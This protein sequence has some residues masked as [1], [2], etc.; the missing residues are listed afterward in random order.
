M[1]QKSVQNTAHTEN[2]FFAKKRK[3]GLSYCCSVSLCWLTTEPFAAAN[4]LAF[5]ICTSLNFG[6]WAITLF[7]LA[8][9]ICTGSFLHCR[10]THEGASA[11]ARTAAMPI[12]RNIVFVLFIT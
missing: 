5:W 12:A 7:F 2:P 4:S 10:I 3:E 1:H 9:T 6:R 8:T 11:T